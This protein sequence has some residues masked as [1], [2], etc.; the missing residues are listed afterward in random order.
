MISEAGVFALAAH[1]A[2]PAG[3]SAIPLGRPVQLPRTTEQSRHVRL[4]RRD[5]VGVFAVS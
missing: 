3:A 5:I 4:V 1:L 2:C